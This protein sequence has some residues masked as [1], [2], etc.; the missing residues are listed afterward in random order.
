[1]K[2]VNQKHK[3]LLPIAETIHYISAVIIR[4]IRSPNTGMVH[5]IKWNFLQHSVLIRIIIMVIH[6]L[7]QWAVIS[8]LHL[9][10]CRGPPPLITPYFNPVTGPGQCIWV[11][12]CVCV[13][14]C[15]SGVQVCL[16]VNVYVGC[17]GVFVCECVCTCMSERK[18]NKVRIRVGLSLNP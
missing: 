7:P 11:F 6:I 12:R 4:N 2:D 18:R 16:C 10:W 15:M 13:R 9:L 17:S 8:V 3:N 14:M 5:S 1:M